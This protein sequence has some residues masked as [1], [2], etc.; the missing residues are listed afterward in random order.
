MKKRLMAMG[1]AGAAVLTIGGASVL[2]VGQGFGPGN[3]SG[4]NGQ[5]SMQGM[6]SSP[7][8]QRAMSQL[9]P[10]LR[11]Q[12]N[13]MHAQMPGNMNFQM[14]GTTGSGMMGGQ[15]MGGR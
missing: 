10:E 4:Y 11:T 6:H 14:N 1:I 3:Q 5:A 7:A 12:C 8:M 15:M 2:A 9:S 13:A